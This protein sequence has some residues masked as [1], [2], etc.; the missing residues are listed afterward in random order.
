MADVSGAKRDGAQTA[1]LSAWQ[2]RA[3]KPAAVLVVIIG[4]G[5][6]T[7]LSESECGCGCARLHGAALARSGSLGQGWL[8]RA[9]SGPDARHGAHWRQA[10]LRRQGDGLLQTTEAD[11]RMG[12]GGVWRGYTAWLGLSDASQCFCATVEGVEA[13]K[14]A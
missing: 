9:D 12:G 1:R 8:A 4:G 2:V 7:M 10:A 5:I 3:E 11:V 6:M 14:Q 13:R